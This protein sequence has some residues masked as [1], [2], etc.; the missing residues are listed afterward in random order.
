MPW[1]FRLTG[2]PAQPLATI[3]FALRASLSLR[4]TPQLLRV[5]SDDDS[6]FALIVEPDDASKIV[7]TDEVP[8]PFSMSK[9][10]CEFS[11]YKCCIFWEQVVLFGVIV[12]LAATEPGARIVAENS[13]CPEYVDVRKEYAAIASRTTAFNSR[14]SVPS[15][16]GYS[17]EFVASVLS[18]KDTGDHSAQAITDLLMVACGGGCPLA[19]LPPET[20]LE[21]ACVVDLGCGGGHDLALAACAVGPTGRVFGVDLTPQMLERAEAVV[22]AVTD[23]TVTCP[24]E[25]I[26]APVDQCGV[27]S[28]PTEHAGKADLVISNGVFNLC[29]DKQGMSRQG[30]TN[31]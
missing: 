25:L 12:S 13:D 22:G 20:S 4:A 18:G 14:S 30:C 28:R 10:V 6:L 29:P 23:G 5:A 11:F 7:R 27:T 9:C 31:L 16:W 1:T 2:V 3:G 19:Q 17:E 15:E 8:A 21:G 24:V 26:C